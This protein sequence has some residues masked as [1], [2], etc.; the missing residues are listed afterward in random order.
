MEEN[1]KGGNNGSSVFAMTIE[2]RG[3]GSVNQQAFFSPT[4]TCITNNLGIK[5]APV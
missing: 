2:Y 4:W 5:P 3:Y 1:R